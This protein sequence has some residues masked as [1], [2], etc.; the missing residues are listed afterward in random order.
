MHRSVEV[1]PSSCR[2]RN[3]LQVQ[4]PAAGLGTN[5]RLM[6]RLVEA[7]LSNCRLRKQLQAHAQVCRGKAVPTVGSG[8]NCRLMYRSVEARPSS[9]RFRNQGQSQVGRTDWSHAK[10]NQSQAQVKGAG[11][12]GTVCEVPESLISRQNWSAGHGLRIRVIHR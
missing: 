3:Q 11:P 9:C 12:L 6:H 5:C 8:T 4:E 7:R 2:F 10:K 1:R